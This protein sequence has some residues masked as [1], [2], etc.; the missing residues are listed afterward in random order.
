VPPLSSPLYFQALA[1]VV[2]LLGIAVGICLGYALLVRWLE[3]R[4]WRG[5]RRLWLLPLLLLP[6]ALR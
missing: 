6:L 1:D 4:G 3:R 5:A 2:G